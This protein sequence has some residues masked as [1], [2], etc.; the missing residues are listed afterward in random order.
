MGYTAGIIKLSQATAADRRPLPT[1]LPPLP[2]HQRGPPSGGLSLGLEI[3][4]ES[5]E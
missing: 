2:H 1:V 4:R 3:S 5:D